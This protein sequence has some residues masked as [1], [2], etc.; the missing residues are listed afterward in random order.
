MIGLGINIRRHR[1]QSGVTPEPTPPAPA[2]LL[3]HYLP[4]LRSF[5]NN[6]DANA[7]DG[8]GIKTWIDDIN[9]YN[10]GQPTAGVRP[11]FKPT[12]FSLPC[13]QFD[14][15]SSHWML[16]ATAFPAD[17]APYTVAFIWR[18]RTTF[19]VNCCVFGSNRSGAG[20]YFINEAGSMVMN[21]G[22]SVLGS[23]YTNDAW[24]STILVA[25]AASSKHYKN[26]TLIGTGNPGN[27]ALAGFTLG[28]YF[29]GGDTSNMY[30]SEFLVYNKEISGAELTALNAYMVAKT[31]A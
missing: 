21:A 30:V 9:G 10:L 17:T 3:A 6:A 22:A 24:A 7:A 14:A 26:G 23:A 13:A 20:L 12:L 18:P 25:N 5:K 19:P 4:L 8:E 11:I 2:D 29:T 28:A 15:S 16:N 31:P 1:G 27:R